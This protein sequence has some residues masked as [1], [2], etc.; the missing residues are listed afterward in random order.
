MILK[1][2][3]QGRKSCRK[4]S[5]NNHRTVVR[6]PILGHRC[7]QE[8]SNSTAGGGFQ[9]GHHSLTRSS[10]SLP[11]ARGLRGLY[12][13]RS[14]RRHPDRTVQLGTDKLTGHAGS[15]HSGRGPHNEMV[16]LELMARNQGDRA[17]LQN[18]AQN[19]QP[20]LLKINGKKIK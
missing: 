15:T 2:S 17:R 19:H 13:E 14:S 1:K 20:A 11:G 12:A 10:R 5:P 4:M 6:A 3:G 9:M 8:P 18:T 7:G 16:S